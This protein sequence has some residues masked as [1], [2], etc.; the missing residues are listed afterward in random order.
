MIIANFIK[1][2]DKIIIINPRGI[3]IW[4]IDYS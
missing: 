2:E 4:F 3:I 1:D